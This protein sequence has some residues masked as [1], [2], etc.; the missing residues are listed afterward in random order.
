MYGADIE[1]KLY[2]NEL[3]IFVYQCLT[4]VLIFFLFVW[5]VSLVFRFF[6]LLKIR[7]KIGTNQ[8]LVIDDDDYPEWLESSYISRASNRR[9]V[10]LPSVDVECLYVPFSLAKLS[11]DAGNVFKPTAEACVSCGDG[12]DSGFFS[13]CFGVDRSFWNDLKNGDVIF[14]DMFK[15]CILYSRWE[16]FFCKEKSVFLSI[17]EGSMLEKGSVATPKQDNVSVCLLLKDKDGVVMIVSCASD[18]RVLECLL[19]KGKHVVSLRDTFTEGEDK[20]C[21]VCCSEVKSTI[22]LP[23][24]HICCCNVCLG[25]MDK[26]PVCRSPVGKSKR[27]IIEKRERDII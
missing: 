6:N 2:P 7:K 17:D 16:A 12:G 15:H 14:E 19:C 23:C 25:R 22:L 4:S 8:Y 10:N 9:M 1:A 11:G 3:S 26:C 13:F 21:I 24:R 27:D 18:M 20:D 5:V